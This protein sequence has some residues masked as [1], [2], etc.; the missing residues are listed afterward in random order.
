MTSTDED[1]GMTFSAGKGTFL[2]AAILGAATGSALGKGT[3]N[4]LEDWAGEP[5]L[6]WSRSDSLTPPTSEDQA[7]DEF[8]YP[9]DLTDEDRELLRLHDEALAERGDDL[10]PYD[11]VRRRA[12]LDDA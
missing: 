8:E 12:G 5:S 1:S 4:S 6:Q 3:D 10:V 7:Q 2:T 11:E 9:D